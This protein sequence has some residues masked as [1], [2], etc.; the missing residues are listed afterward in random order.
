[1]IIVALIYTFS[2]SFGSKSHMGYRNQSF[3][4]KEKG[5]KIEKNKKNRYLKSPKKI[6]D[7]KLK[8]D[9]VEDDLYSEADGRWSDTDKEGMKN[10]NDGYYSDAEPEIE[11]EKNNKHFPNSDYRAS[12]V[13]KSSASGRSL[14][15]PHLS[16]NH[17]NSNEDDTNNHADDIYS[18]VESCQ[19]SGHDK[20]KKF[21]GINKCGVFPHTQHAKINP[22]KPSNVP[23]Q[24][25]KSQLQNESNWKYGGRS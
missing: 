17:T 2:E 6:I 10:E 20:K 25:K 24:Y 13:N 7:D 12:P 18:N 4:M 8:Q 11:N 23:S 21:E 14:K 9:Q 15:K 16:L 22:S 3:E 1:M 19:E 5:G